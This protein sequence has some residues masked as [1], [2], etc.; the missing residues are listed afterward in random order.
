MLTSFNDDSCHSSAASMLLGLILAGNIYMVPD[1]GC[2][3]DQTCQQVDVLCKK[4][5]DKE[6]LCPDWYRPNDQLPPP[7]GAGSQ[8]LGGLEAF[9]RPSIN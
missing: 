7:A 6:Y 4:K 2:D 1:V 8:Y 3:N 5:S 9:D